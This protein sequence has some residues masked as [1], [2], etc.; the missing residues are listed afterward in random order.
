VNQN[1]I[2]LAVLILTAGFSARAAEWQPLADPEILRTLFSDT[3]MQT[4]LTGNVQAEATYNSDGT[5]ELRAWDETFPRTWKVKGDD[6]VC[7]G[8]ER[9]T[10]CFQIEQSAEQA[11]TFRGT[12]VATGEQVI[13]SVNRADGVIVIDRQADPERGATLE[14]GAAQPSM[15]EMA[16][17]LSNP[18]TSVASMTFKLQFRSFEGDLPDAEEQSSTT[19]LFQPALPFRREDG[20]KILWRPAFPFIIDQPLYQGGD[21]WEEETGMGDISFDLAYAFAPKEDDPG[22]LLALGIFTSL[23]TVDEDLGFGETTTLGPEL[24][25]GRASKENIW[26]LF[27][28]HQWDVGGDVDVSLTSLQIFYS[29]FGDGGLVYGTSPILAYDHEGDAWTIPLNF[30]VS[31]TI[32]VGGRPWKIGGEINYYIEQPDAFGP[33]WMI[34]FSVAP[35]VKNRLAD[36]FK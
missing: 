23:P 7:I 2:I 14:G 36:W 22:L 13:F 30:S 18:N 26:G 35:V 3:V 1:P 29:V 17:E 4:T 25:Y 10:N 11:D 15:D 31:K 24:L 28:S 27:P 19:F 12:D 8:T 34:S 5:G 32:A 9:G 6:Q 16:K 33:E 21:D 20:S